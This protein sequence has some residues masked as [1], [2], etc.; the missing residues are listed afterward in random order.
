MI[1]LCSLI[2]HY[3]FILIFIYLLKKPVY[4]HEPGHETFHLQQSN[5]S[6][7]MLHVL[8]CYI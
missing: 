1:R 6:N 5:Q 3:L 7:N 2:G 4:K 8:L